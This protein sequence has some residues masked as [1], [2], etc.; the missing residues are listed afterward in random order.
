MF[1]FMHDVFDACSNVG[2]K[3]SDAFFLTGEH[4]HDACKPGIPSGAL[5]R[6]NL[7]RGTMHRDQ[8]DWFVTN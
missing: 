4:M 7:L 1:D 5:R 2:N 8:R 6:V 3:C